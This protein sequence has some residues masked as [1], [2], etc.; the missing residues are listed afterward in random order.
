MSE[1]AFWQHQFAVF[2]SFGGTFFRRSRTRRIATGFSSLTPPA[3]CIAPAIHQPKRRILR[4]FHPRSGLAARGR[5]FDRVLH[6]AP[7]SLERP[8]VLPLLEWPSGK[9]GNNR[10]VGDGRS[11]LSGGDTPATHQATRF[12]PTRPSPE[13]C[14]EWL[15]PEDHL[16]SFQHTP[17]LRTARS[18]R[19]LPRTYPATF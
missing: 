4:A 15:T 11:A 9:P 8:V 13:P 2:H 12:T 18:D 17:S 16:G 6:N 1:A 14:Y 5:R 10:Q 3:W 19:P 7:A